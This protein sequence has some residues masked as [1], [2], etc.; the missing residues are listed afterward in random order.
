MM[1]KDLCRKGVIVVGGLIKIPGREFWLSGVSKSRPYYPYTPNR[2]LPITDE[3][4]VLIAS[5]FGVTY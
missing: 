2:S 1:A 5:R 4:T 3:T